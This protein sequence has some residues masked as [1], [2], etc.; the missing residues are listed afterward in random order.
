M[1]PHRKICCPVD[2]SDASRLALLEAADL[3]RSFGA[4][5]AL[6]HVA[7]PVASPAAE[8]LLAPPARHGE[9]DPDAPQLLAAWGSEAEALAGRAVQTRL[10]SG[11]PG[12]EILR[13]AREGGFD[14][15]VVGSHGRSGL[16]HLVLG[17]VAEELVRAAPCPVLVVRRSAAQPGATAAD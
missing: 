2:F 15:L 14:L 9:E 5:L 7:P 12:Q 11:R 8:A 4:E 16:R 17:S 1:S 10:S 13:Y 3:A 6:V